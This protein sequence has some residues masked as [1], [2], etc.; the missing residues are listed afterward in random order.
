MRKD[1]SSIRQGYK[2]LCFSYYRD[3]RY[4]KLPAK[5]TKCIH[6]DTEF[7]VQYISAE[8]SDNTINLVD[9]R[10]ITLE[11]NPIPNKKIKSKAGTINY[12]RSM[13]FME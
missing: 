12:R 5:I 11:Q 9:K 1:E 7:L 13:V 3:C 6:Q 10:K 4:I 2:R 8:A